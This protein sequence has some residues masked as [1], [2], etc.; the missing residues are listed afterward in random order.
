MKKIIALIFCIVFTLS[1]GAA[2]VWGIASDED[3]T[4]LIP[5]V[6]MLAFTCLF[7]FLLCKEIFV[8]DNAYSL[9]SSQILLKRRG[10]VTARIEIADTENIKFV[11]DAI[12]GDVEIITF[13][14]CKKRFYIRLNADNREEFTAAL[15]TEPHGTTSNFLY[16]LIMLFNH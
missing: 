8:G 13:R 9:D 3:M 2:F 4:F 12:S 14:Y 11:C 15:S 7:I 10:V 5:A 6:L 1:L 16:Y